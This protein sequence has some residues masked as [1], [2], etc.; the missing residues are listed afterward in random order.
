[1]GKVRGIQ[2]RTGPE[3]KGPTG[4]LKGDCMEKVHNIDFIDYFE[5]DVDDLIKKAIKE[6][7]SFKELLFKTV[8]LLA[9]V[10]KA[11]A[12]GTRRRRKDGTY[13]KQEDGSW[14]RI[15]EPSS[16]AGEDF[17]DTTQDEGEEEPTDI[18]SMRDDLAGRW[19]GGNAGTL[20]ELIV[21]QMS[22]ED[23]SSQGYDNK[24]DMMTDLE[25]NFDSS[26]LAKMYVDSLSDDA[27]VESH[28]SITW[29]VP[30]EEETSDAMDI[31]RDSYDTQFTDEELRQEYQKL[32][33]DLDSSEFDSLNNMN[34]EELVNAIMGRI[35]H[36]KGFKQ[37]ED[38]SEGEVSEERVQL[39]AQIDDLFDE[40]GLEGHEY[41][42]AIE[43]AKNA[44]DE[45]LREDIKQLTEDLKDES[46]EGRQDDDDG[47]W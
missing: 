24:E 37:P 34:H 6:K 27:I 19:A 12:P 31:L 2:D 30:K 47:W 43:D 32:V 7:W 23:I 36:T 26:D 3:G 44:T 14:V 4:R 33:P 11:Y 39:L 41:Q 18:D 13:E 46:G 10:E 21:N 38:E 29:E 8:D 22:D 20:S 1:M 15:T 40:L 35:Q 5:E 9:G 25:S 16:Q 28:D 17:E 42:Q 45:E